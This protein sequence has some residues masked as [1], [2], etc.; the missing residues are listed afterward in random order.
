MI[1]TASQI[2]AMDRT[3]RLNLI[4][5]FP[6]MKPVNLVGTISSE[7]LSNL[8]IISSVVHIG[9]DPPLIGF[10]MRPSNTPRHTY[11]NIKE[12]NEFSINMVT[13]KFVDRAHFT[14]GKFSANVSEFQSCGFT[15]SYIAGYHAPLVKESPVKAILS[16]EEEVHLSSSNSILIV[17]K[18]QCLWLQEST[19]QED[20]NINMEKCRPVA[21]SGLGTYFQPTQLASFPYVGS[22]VK[23]LR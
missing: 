13:H 10:M 19:L 6:G 11:T 4:N 15:E 16:F 9:S 21:V 20:G 5:S 18:I 8:A 22:K 2:Q 17:G 1:F 14:S 23:G 3:Y 12:A 7:G